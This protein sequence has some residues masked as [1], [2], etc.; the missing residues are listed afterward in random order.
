MALKAC[1]YPYRL[2]FKQPAR[3]SR[4]TMHDK[5]TWFVKVWDEER[6]EVFGL[7]ECAMF[8]GLSPEDNPYFEKILNKACET[9]NEID[10]KILQGWSSIRFGIE[11]ALRDLDNGG[12]RIIYDT[13]WS[14]GEARMTINGLIW[15]GDKHQMLKQI[16]DKV[17]AGFK[18]LKLKI[19]GIAFDDEIALLGH[20]R[21]VFPTSGLEIRLDANG[22]FSPD[23]ALSRLERLAQFDIHS[24]EQ[25]I[26][27]GD[28]EAMARICAASP[29]P[30]AL[31][32][33]LIGISETAAKR[34]LLETVR[35]AYIILKPSLCGGL[36]G[37]YE[38]VKLAGETGCGWWITSALESNVGLNAIAQFA[39]SLSPEIPQGLG[40]GALYTD[41]IPSPLRLDGDKIY[42]DTA[43]S[44]NLTPILG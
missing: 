23:D 11:T 36:T 4:M 14:R 7:G 5:E 27:A 42:Y 24:I 30:V 8:R 40:T 25:P 17:A 29:I 28:R 21:K 3:T 35:P 1:Y 20:I 12:R 44:W 34:R 43:A 2:H 22:A 13:P 41:N 38:W 15:M 6:P 26:P 16:D 32:E 9:I 39:S 18:C 31:D 10:V 33:S 19:G 37:V